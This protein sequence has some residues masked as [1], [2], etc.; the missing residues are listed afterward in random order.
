MPKPLYGFKPPGRAMR[1]GSAS[2][3]VRSPTFLCLDMPAAPVPGFSACDTAVIVGSGIKGLEPDFLADGVRQRLHDPAVVGEDPAVVG[4]DAAV[5]E[6]Y[7]SNPRDAL[8][9]LCEAFGVEPL[10]V[11]DLCL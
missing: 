4:K 3:L 10:H 8:L 11:D 6:E 1:P 5:V 7:R 2:E 9:K